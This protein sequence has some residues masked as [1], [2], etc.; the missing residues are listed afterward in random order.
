MN[1]WHGN[2]LTISI[3]G[4]S[5]GEGVGA[6][7]D[8]MPAGLPLDF[9]HIDH[10]L[11]QRKPKGGATTP[12]K[13]NDEYEILS[14]V[15]DGVTNGAPL[16]IFFRNRDVKRS[17]YKVDIPRPSHADFPAY[18][19][20]DGKC[21]LSGGGHFSARLT[22]P[23]VFLGAI[24]ESELKKRG[25]QTAVSIRSIGDI[26]GKSFYNV[27]ITDALMQRLDSEFSLID[28]SVKADMEKLLSDCR[29]SKNTVGATVELCMTGLPVGLGEPFFDSVESRLSQLMF[30]IPAVKAVEFGKGFSLAKMYGQDANDEYDADG[31]KRFFEGDGSAKVCFSNNAG[32]IAGGLTTSMPLIMRV[33]FKPIPSVGIPQRSFSLTSL[34][35][36]EL[37]IDGRH[38]VCAAI[39]GAVIVRACAAIGMYD[40]L[41]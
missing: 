2:K 1:T 17:D 28:E 21:D 41:K 37:V 15:T 12:R 6:V 11:S 32:G 39:R 13:E 5:H 8:G 16:C 27:D 22:A 23:L 36:A 3:F 34:E 9:A 7:L 30:S 19:K 10:M 25:I 18:V 20:Y 35:P 14:G 24:C 29:E 38:D 40:Y 33:A 31:V 4:E 26:V